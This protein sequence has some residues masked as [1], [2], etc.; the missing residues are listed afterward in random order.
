MA[1]E[2]RNPPLPPDRLNEMRRWTIRP[3]EAGV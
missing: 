3:H 2:A 1:S